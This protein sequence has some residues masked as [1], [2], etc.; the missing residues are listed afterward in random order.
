MIAIVLFDDIILLY[1]V[2][3]TKSSLFKNFLEPKNLLNI[4]MNILIPA[5]GLGTRFKESHDSPKNMIDVKGD[6]MLVAAV[7]SLGLNKDGNQFIFLLPE[8]ML[9]DTHNLLGTRLQQEFPGCKV[10]VVV[11]QTEGAAQTAIQAHQYIENDEELLI[12][13][14]DQ[15]MHWD[16]KLR[17]DVFEK[18]REF[19]AGII[20]L[21]S[22]DP[23]HSYLDLVTGAIFEKEVQ[24]GNM[25]LTG[26][27]YFK[28]GSDFITSTRLMMQSGMK[29]QGEYYIGPVYNWFEG[30]A[31]FYQIE[32][33]DIS[34]IGTP[35]D[36]ADYLEK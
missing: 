28:K 10:L 23:K 33:K 6:P 13:N 15:I 25:A 21:E 3:G 19:E 24:A 36:L 26:L 7:K 1:W 18:L 9:D 16:D 2:L 5:A 34:F 12:A 22:D 17:D 8:D 30:E 27:H 29:S 20:C 32:S 4:S 35:Q 11:G 14:C 31:G